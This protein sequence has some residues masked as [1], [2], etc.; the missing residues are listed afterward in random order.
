MTLDQGA[1]GY[2]GGIPRATTYDRSPRAVLAAVSYSSEVV[3]VE[4]SDA[5]RDPDTRS[6]L[7]ELQFLVWGCS[8]HGRLYGLMYTISTYEILALAA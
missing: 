5:Q 3:M 8:S 1:Q 6:P 2:P 7:L 4:L